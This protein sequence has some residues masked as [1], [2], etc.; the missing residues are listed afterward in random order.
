MAV[1][2]LLTA[3]ARAIA[4]DDGDDGYIEGEPPATRDVGGGR[5]AVNAAGTLERQYSATI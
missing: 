3:I 1:A 4:E 5:G 2:T